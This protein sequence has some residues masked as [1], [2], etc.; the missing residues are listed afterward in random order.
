MYNF[1]SWKSTLFTLFK[2]DYCHESVLG[3]DR[4]FNNIK[5]MLSKTCMP[6]ETDTNI[7]LEWCMSKKLIDMWMKSLLIFTF[8]HIWWAN[9][10]AEKYWQFNQKVTDVESVVI[11]QNW[12]MHHTIKCEMGAFLN[13]HKWRLKTEE[14]L[15]QTKGT[16]FFLGKTFWNW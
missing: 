8:P 3:M 10:R 11:D 6:L 5:L 13:Y 2:S 12:K 9:G 15:W 7:P 14:K 4:W 1:F 16:D